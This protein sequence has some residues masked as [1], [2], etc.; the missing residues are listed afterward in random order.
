MN[1][2]LL[3]ASQ[4]SPALSGRVR[5]LADFMYSQRRRRRSLKR[6]A[7]ELDRFAQDAELTSFIVETLQ[8]QPRLPRLGWQDYKPYMTLLACSAEPHSFCYLS[9]DLVAVYEKEFSTGELMFFCDLLRSLRGRSHLNCV[10]NRVCDYFFRARRDTLRHCP[11]PVKEVEIQYAESRLKEL[12]KAV[13][14]LKV[15][16]YKWHTYTAEEMAE[17]CGMSYSH[18]RERF[19]DFYGCSASEWLR[20]ERIARITEDFSY[21]PQL[22]LKEVAERNRFQSPS[23]FADFCNQNLC[24]S[25]TELKEKGYEEW[26]ERRLRYYNE[27]LR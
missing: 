21:R 18:F 7:D 23:N 19:H 10:W 22:P 5:E 26:E 20:R 9:N 12:E 27:H 4:G 24:K 16:M 11:T 8:S 6:L 3:R 25:P 14:R 15:R 2:V 17:M 1:D 13:F